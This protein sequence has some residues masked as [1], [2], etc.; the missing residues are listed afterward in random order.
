[1]SLRRR[2]GL[3]SAAA[4]AVTVVLAS[5]IIYLLVRDNLRDEVDQDLRRQAERA[6][7]LAGAAG[8]GLGE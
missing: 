1:M 6:E 2:L 4:V 7:A 3:L 8:A 5:A